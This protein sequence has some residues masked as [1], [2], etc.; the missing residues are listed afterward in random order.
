MKKED[1]VVN[2][3]P[4]L[5]EILQDG[6]QF[7]QNLYTMNF[8]KAYYIMLSKTYEK[9]DPEY[10][11]ILKEAAQCFDENEVFGIEKFREHYEKSY[12][13]EYVSEPK[14]AAAIFFF[15]KDAFDIIKSR[16]DMESLTSSE[17]YMGIS[18]FYKLTAP[19]RNPNI[20]IKEG[21]TKCYYD[22]PG[23]STYFHEDLFAQME[24]IN[25]ECQ[26]TIDIFM[27]PDEQEQNL[28]NIENNYNDLE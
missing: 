5:A 1:T 15:Y 17:K 7:A 25:R 26:T 24:Y 6:L 13:L 12:N 27:T 2:Y 16:I 14:A 11:S 23:N 8:Q 3:R 28:G 10:A 9:A 20:Q 21:Y 4:E 19:I 22:M 18:F